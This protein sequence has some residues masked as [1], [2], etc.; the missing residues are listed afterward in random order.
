MERMK[1]GKKMKFE[2]NQV[3]L[4]KVVN[5]LVNRPYAEVAQLIAE[6]NQNIK[7]IE[8]PQEQEQEKV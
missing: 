3:V 2:I 6:I 7:P 1:G 4:E 5:Y 8:A